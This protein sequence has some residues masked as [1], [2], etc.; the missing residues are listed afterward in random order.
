MTCSYISGERRARSTTG[1][2]NVVELFKRNEPLFGV[3]RSVSQPRLLKGKR[4][5]SPLLKTS[6]WVRAESASDEATVTVYVG[7][8]YGGQFAL[9]N[10]LKPGRVYFSP[11]LRRSWRKCR[12]Y[13]VSQFPGILFITTSIENCGDRRRTSA[14]SARASC[15]RPSS[16]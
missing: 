5:E 12:W 7:A 14:A 6:T 10:T 13:G 8:E 2:A 9:Q 15:S 16:L 11:A 4:D 1:I 3:S